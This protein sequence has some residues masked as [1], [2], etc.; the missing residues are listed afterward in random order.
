MLNTTL[1]PTE[2]SEPAPLPNWRVQAAG[3]WRRIDRY[4]WSL[5]IVAAGAVLSEALY[6]TF[7]MTRLSLVF[8]GA[9]LVAA[10]YFGR[11]AAIFSAVVAFLIYNFYLVEPR[12]TVQLA[13]P[14]ELLTLAL[15]LTVALVTGTLAGRVRDE[16]VQRRAR[17]HTLATLFGASR[18]MSATEHEAVLADQ[19]VEAVAKA[20][21]SRAVLFR[22]DGSIHRF[23][24]AGERPDS[25]A[26]A[27]AVSRAAQASA[28][29]TTVTGGLWRGRALRADE[30]V[31]GAV[32]WR[33][34][35]PGPA[36]RR[37]RGV[38]WTSWWIWGRPPWRAPGSVPRRP[39]SRPSRR[40]STLGPPCC[41]RSP[42]TFGL[43]SLPSWPPPP[44][45]WNTT[46][47]SLPT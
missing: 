15:F 18:A 30:Q 25:G 38:S 2:Y 32:V 35:P 21:H 8:L 23:A 20:V 11:S 28:P 42:T 34:T 24:A 14:D 9:V 12:F 40:R 36:P 31:L 33:V 41:P 5:M 39:R 17:E 16:V 29:G 43:R 1:P 44:A 37:T 27:V 45:S 6:R 22:L 10:L 19:L 3:A 46:S 7:D 47:S 4:V 13:E 26:D